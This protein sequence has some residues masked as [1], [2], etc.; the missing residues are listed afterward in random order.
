MKPQGGLCRC[1]GKLPP[2]KALHLLPE[3]G[4]TQERTLEAV[5]CSAS[6]R[7]RYFFL[8]DSQVFWRL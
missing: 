8:L 5:R 4:A 7:L 3:A 2:N 1:G 6:V